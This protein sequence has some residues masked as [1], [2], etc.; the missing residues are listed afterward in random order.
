MIIEYL[1]DGLLLRDVDV[2]AAAAG[3][4][5]AALVAR[6]SAG[7]DGYEQRAGGLFLDAGALLRLTASECAAIGVEVF[8]GMVRLREVGISGSG[9]YYWECDWAGAAGLPFGVWL[10]RQGRNLLLGP[11]HREVVALAQ[12]VAGAPRDRV[13]RCAAHVQALAGAHADSVELSGQLQARRVHVADSLRISVEQAAGEDALRPVA[14]LAAREGDHTRPLPLGEQGRAIVAAHLDLDGCVVPI[15][16][17]T[18]VVVPAEVARAA[19][20]TELAAHATGPERTRFLQNPTAFLADPEVFD[21]KDYSERVI[22][23]GFAPPGSTTAGRTA[24]RDWADD[25]GGVLMDTP[26]GETWVPSAE[27]PKLYDALVA[28]RTGGQEQVSW[29]GKPIPVRPEVIAALAEVKRTPQGDATA[30]AGAPGEKPRPRILLI[31]DNE[32]SLSYERYRRAARP[33]EV[34]AI[35]GLR[36]ALRAHQLEGVGRLQQLWRDGWSGALLCDDMGLGKTLQALAFAAWAR[37]HVGGTADL[38]IAVVAPPSLLGPWL[39]EMTEKLEDD[40]FGRVLWGPREAPPAGC[41]RL[42]LRLDDFLVGSRG[43]NQAVLDSVDVDVRKL[44]ALAP[45]ML[46]IGYDSLRRYQFAL[47]KLRIGLL[48]ADEAQEVKDPTSLRSRALRAMRYEFALVLTGTPI[49]NGWR[50]LWTLCDAAVPGF[51]GTLKEFSRA[52]ASTADAVTTGGR[53]AG[54][55]DRVLVR[56]TRASALADLPPRTIT[57]QAREMPAGQSL[58]YG[59]ALA[60]RAVDNA[61]LLSLLSDLGRISLHPRLRADLRDE[62]EARTWISGSA[63]TA[64]AWEALERFRREG[65]AVLLFVRSLAMQETVQKALQLTFRL[66]DVPVLNGAVSLSGRS[67]LVN[68]MREGHGFRV[69]L[70]SPDVGGAGWN[71]QFANKAVLLER[72]W[73]PAIEAQMIARVHRLGQTRAVEIVLTLA[74]MPGR[75]TFDVILDELL[76]EK[77]ALAEAVLA[78]T[79]LTDSELTGRF[80]R[81]LGADP[82]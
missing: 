58:A 25:P 32:I 78:P 26:L 11:E 76:R 12:Q 56:R 72:P 1:P 40:L 36:C 4:S 74:T 34:A 5:A 53:L 2:H 65:V 69:M 49:E 41:P 47:G 28:A 62:T 54:A 57:V 37:R 81:E 6:W 64:A 70:V 82:Q 16:G 35:R 21:E 27:V 24:A 13:L 18:S 50:D 80:A 79:S 52:Y 8:S 22:G 31:R 60:R 44:R 48:I 77:I 51:L 17:N 71:L 75:R 14:V 29:G 19:L 33:G 45:D 66:T 23:A 67:R 73:N 3:A 39:Q 38:P 43:G 63:R 68:E 42:L 20:I 15:G 10:Q 9:G 46:L 61:A 55:L 30:T 7:E 59:A